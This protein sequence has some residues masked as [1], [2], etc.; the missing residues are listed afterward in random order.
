MRMN[1]PLPEEAASSSRIRVLVQAP[2]AALAEVCPWC[3]QPLGGQ[4]FVVFR[5]GE[6]RSVSQLRYIGRR[7]YLWF[8][9]P[10]GCLCPETSRVVPK[11]YREGV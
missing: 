5:Q 2:V 11:A 3:G 10:E 4:V 7:E 9:R 1:A 8:H 6:V